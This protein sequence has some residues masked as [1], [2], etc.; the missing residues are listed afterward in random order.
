MLSGAAVLPKAVSPRPERGTPLRDGVSGVERRRRSWRRSRSTRRV[1]AGLSPPKPRP[2]FFE[3]SLVCTVIWSRYGGPAPPT[4]RLRS[5][6][7]IARPTD[8]ARTKCQVARRKPQFIGNP[9]KCARLRQPR[10]QVTLGLSQL[11]LANAVPCEAGRQPA[12][13]PRKGKKG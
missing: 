8:Y 2:Q 4:L 7:A 6:Q 1:S 5:T 12:T 10:L 9:S 13:G 11:S 3:E